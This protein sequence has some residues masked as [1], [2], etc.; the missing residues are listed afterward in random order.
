MTNAGSVDHHGRVTTPWTATSR[1]WTTCSTAGGT[2]QVTLVGHSYGTELAA[3]YCL[4]QPDRVT[5]LV[6]LA[7]PF[8]GAW[9]D[10]D[11]STRQGRMTEVQRARLAE[12]DATKDRT[13]EQEEEL[14]ILSWFPDHHDQ[15]RAWSWASNA[16]RTRR[17]VNWAMNNQISTDRHAVPL[18]DL[19]DELAAA[20]PAATILIGGAGDPRPASA[21]EQLGRRLERPTVVIPG[22]GHEP[23]L[24]EPDLFRRE[25]RSAVLR[26]PAN[27]K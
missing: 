16:A 9:R 22:A 19:L 6:S 26:A 18:E 12:L 5:G 20:V 23:W 3:R 14:L 8:V 27:S 2:T 17:P 7:G 1:T 25:F 13:E 15:D 21:I 10:A 4:R 11:R 24:E